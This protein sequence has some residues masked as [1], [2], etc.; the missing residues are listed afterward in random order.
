MVAIFPTLLMGSKIRFAPASKA[1]CRVPAKF[2]T[3]VILPPRLISPSTTSWLCNALPSRPEHRVIKLARVMVEADLFDTIK[4]EIP[5]LIRQVIRDTGY[6]RHFP[7]IDPDTC[8]IRLQLNEQSGDIR[9]GVENGGAGDQGLVFGYATE[10]T[11]ELIPL[12]ITLAHKLMQRQAQLRA[13]G[14]IPWLRPDAK[15]QV[16]RATMTGL[17]VV[18][19][20]RC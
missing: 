19:V 10:E 14:T 16:T 12:L 13:S 4:A 1:T 11:P 15:S 2:S 7:G 20:I 8:E 9:Q 3:G 17:K 18:S 6:T 5:D